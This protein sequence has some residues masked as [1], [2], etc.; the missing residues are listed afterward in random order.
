MSLREY[1]LIMFS[2][3]LAD[4]SKEAQKEAVRRLNDYVDQYP[5]IWR[6]KKASDDSF[7]LSYSGKIY[8]YAHYAKAAG[9]KFQPEVIRAHVTHEER[10]KVEGFGFK[11]EPIIYP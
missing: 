10:S 7:D 9:I 3:N 8:L 6:P 1:S 5:D 2:R 11:V 4:Q